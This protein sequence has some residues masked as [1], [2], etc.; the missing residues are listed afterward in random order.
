VSGQHSSHHD[1]VA[2]SQGEHD[3]N[4]LLAQDLNTH[5]PRAMT[6]SND[7]RRPEIIRL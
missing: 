4:D 1:V 3:S 7:S 5:H 2:R 6:M